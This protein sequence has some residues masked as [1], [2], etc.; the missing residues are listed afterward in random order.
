MQAWVGREEK[1]LTGLN[2]AACTR[3][4]ACWRQ[5]ERPQE[6]SLTRPHSDCPRPQGCRSPG[7]AG[8]PSKA[9]GPGDRMRPGCRVWAGEV[10]W[11]PAPCAIRPSSEK[12]PRG[13]PTQPCLRAVGLTS[14]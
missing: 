12:G 4:P 13:L 10:G 6:T 9:G 11:R 7:E 1:Y 5:G 3:L 14:S 8:C 2:L